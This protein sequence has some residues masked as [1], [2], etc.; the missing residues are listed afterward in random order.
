M[1]DLK[2]AAE[3]QHIEHIGASAAAAAAATSTTTTT[4][5]ITAAATITSASTTLLGRPGFLLDSC[6][7]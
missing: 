3:G 5:A 2:F 6:R 1:V 4:T 7:F